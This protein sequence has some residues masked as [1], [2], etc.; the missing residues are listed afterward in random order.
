MCKCSKC[1]KTIK[2]SHQSWALKSLTE[3][4]CEECA[5][6]EDEKDLELLRAIKRGEDI[7]KFI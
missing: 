6:E 4:Y 5:K 2:E 7:S 3:G 1:G